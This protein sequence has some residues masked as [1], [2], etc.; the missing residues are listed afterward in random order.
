LRS[1]I[2]YYAAHLDART[3]FAQVRFRS[4]R[5]GD[6]LSGILLGE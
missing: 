3:G 1:Q 4:H 5:F 2:G 6:T